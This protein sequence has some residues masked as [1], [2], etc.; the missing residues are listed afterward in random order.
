MELHNV[1]DFPILSLSIFL[2]TLGALIIWLFVRG[3]N[4]VRWASLIVAVA[5]FLVTLPLVLQ[6]DSTTSH[7]QFEEFH[8]WIP[9]FNVNYQLGVDGI[10][11]P[12][13]VLTSLLTVICII[14]AWSCIQSRVKEYMIAFLVLE[15][16]LIGVF[17]ALDAILFYFFWEAMLIPMYLIIGIWGGKNRVYATIKF[18]LYTLAGSLLMLI[19]VL[20]MYFKAGHTFSLLAF[21]DYP[22]DFTWQFW[23]W[24]A[25]F[26]AFAV[27]VP[28]WPVHT[29]L[30]DAHTEAPTAGSVILAGILLKMGAYG[31]LRFSL[32]MLPDASQ[33][34]VPLM[35]G[36][37]L[38]AIVYISLVAMMQTDMKRLIAYSSIAHMGFVTLGTFMFTQAALEGAVIGMI[39]HGFVAAAL[40]LCV[41]V[42]YDRLHTREIGDYGGVV[43]VMPV[44]AAVMLFFCMAN[45][46]LP[47][48]SAFVGEIM[49]LIGTFEAAPAHLGVSAMWIAVAAATSVILSACYTLWMYK[50]VVM[51]DLVKDSVK[52][53]KDMSFREF[54]YFVPLMILT[55]WIGFYPLPVLDLLHVSV[56]HLIDQVSTSKL[57]AAAALLQAMPAAEAAHH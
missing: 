10:S 14:S 32:P 54:G 50:R 34:F 38:V 42:M 7:M 15:T 51:G 33:Y 20:A 46:A 31:F 27:K 28:M 52:T 2:P 18:F 56:S 45:I 30:P 24:I 17:S 47:G 4:A 22:F 53:M 36:L 16:T 19:A 23:I 11:M 29:W 6:F 37:S 9:A 26:I 21:M 5:T 12:F 8:H 25:F 35:V 44:F 48:A 13:I 49:V 41:G 43:N 55:L 40:F 3:D 57:D 1:L 39:S